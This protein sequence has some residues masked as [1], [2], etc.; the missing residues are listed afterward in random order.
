M[1]PRMAL[2][3]FT[4]T[5]Q[6]VLGLRPARVAMCLALAF[7]CV[8][9]ASDIAAPVAEK[10]AAETAAPVKKEKKTVKKKTM[11]KAAE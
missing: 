2:H 7:A 5:R 8:C 4:T 10:P 1:R 3:L 6:G 9:L 11:K